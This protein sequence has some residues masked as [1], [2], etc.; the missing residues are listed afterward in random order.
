MLS[1]FDLD[2]YYL[3]WIVVF[4]RFGKYVKFNFGNRVVLNVLEIYV[5]LYC[6]TFEWFNNF[7]FFFIEIL[8][9][10][11]FE[12][13]KMYFYEGF[14][15]KCKF[16]KLEVVVYINGFVVIFKDENGKLGFL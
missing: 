3:Y 16:I 13:E 7:D 9:L 2:F 14:D 4:L 8:C 12:I 11:G 10:G 5:I 1:Y 15:D 6:S